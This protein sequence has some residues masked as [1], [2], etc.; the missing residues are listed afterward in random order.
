MPG[1]SRAW[2]G[3]GGPTEA[4]GGLFAIKYPFKEWKG[5]GCWEDKGVRVGN[6]DRRAEPSL[7]PPS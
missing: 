3:A 5:G 1:L 6:Q 4:S 7:L 2:V